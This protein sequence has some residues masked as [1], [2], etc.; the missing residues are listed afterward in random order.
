MAADIEPDTAGVKS[1]FR[2]LQVLEH[3]ART[4]RPA[5]ASELREALG[6][7]KSSCF[8]LMETLKNAGYV[9]WV[10][11]DQGY[12]PTMKWF[13]LSRLVAE[14]DPVLL[15]VEPHLEAIR[16]ATGETAILAK[17]DDT[18]V[19]YLAVVESRHIVRFSASAGDHRP[20]HPASTGRA[21]LALMTP[22]ERHELI[23]RLP[24]TRYTP[25]TCTSPRKL[26]GIIEQE[27]AQGW[28]V[29]LGAHMSDTASVSVPLHFGLEH[30]ALAVGAP[31]ARLDG[32]VPKI[33]K[34]LA[35]HARQIE[36][37]SQ[38]GVRKR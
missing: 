26:A 21:L 2:V 15:V 11:R 13:N 5:L 19:L 37:Q 20:V 7:P 18:R 4:R 12:Y 22:E 29:N 30:Y 14:N 25:A 17:L 28:H 3:F 1:A 33:A 9:Y 36:T 35:L 23:A 34:E 6:L 38:A 32:R 16:D 27:M 31:L 10:G 24:L 8:A